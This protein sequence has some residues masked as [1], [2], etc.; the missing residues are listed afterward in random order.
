MASPR[1]FQQHKATSLL[2]N[3]AQGVRFAG[4]NAEC[5]HRI[6]SSHECKDGMVAS[7]NPLDCPKDASTQVAEHRAA[8]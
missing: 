3:P 1:S 7:V 4:K 8:G 6:H 5:S 2:C